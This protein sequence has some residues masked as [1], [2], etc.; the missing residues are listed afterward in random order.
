M[1]NSDVSNVHGS[2]PSSKRGSIVSRTTQAQRHWYCSN[3]F[4]QISLFNIQ[5]RTIYK[6]LCLFAKSNAD[7]HFCEVHPGGDK[8]PLDEST[9]LN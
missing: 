2:F 9:A 8:Q 5:K 6:A 7:L 4:D 1:G 3:A